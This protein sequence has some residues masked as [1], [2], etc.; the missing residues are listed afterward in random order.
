MPAKTAQAGLYSER[1][2]HEGAQPLFYARRLY[3]L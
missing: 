1:L 3:F 2:R